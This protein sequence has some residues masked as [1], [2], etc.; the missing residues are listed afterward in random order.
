MEYYDDLAKQE[1]ASGKKQRE[2][3]VECPRCGSPLTGMIV[4]NGIKFKCMDEKCSYARLEHTE[5]R[6]L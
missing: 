4:Y 6:H 1:I 2:S 5:V 3:T